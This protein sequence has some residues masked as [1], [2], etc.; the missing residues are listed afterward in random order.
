LEAFAQRITQWV[1]SSWAF[2][3]ALGLV[4]VWVL[5]GPIFDYSNTWQLVINTGTT[6]MTFLMLFLLQRSQNHESAAMH[7]K[8]NELVAGLEGASNEL[9][10]AEDLSEADLRK[11][12]EHYLGLARHFGHAAKTRAERSAAT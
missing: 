7:M 1:G 3:A 6:I 2:L 11:L 9:I 5:S 12:H 4:A 10:D 8:L